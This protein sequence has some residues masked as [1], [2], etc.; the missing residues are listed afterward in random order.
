M[1][2]KQLDDVVDICGMLGDA[3][4]AEIIA[5]LAKGSKSVTQLCN[6][7]K[8]AQ[9]MTSYHLALLRMGK[10]LIRNRRGKQMIYSLN[11]E[12]LKP[13]EKFLAEV[14]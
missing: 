10:L 13:V 6:E 7:L 11:K 2:G 1:R 3:T 4:R 8:V 5:I 12:R 14:K 9:P